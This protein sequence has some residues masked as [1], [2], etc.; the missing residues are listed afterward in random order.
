MVSKI[1][2]YFF[3]KFNY[4]DKEESLRVSVLSRISK[5]RK[6][7]LSFLYFLS[8]GSIILLVGVVYYFLISF[9]QSSGETGF[10]SYLSLIFSDFSSIGLFWKEVGVSLLASL[11]IFEISALLFSF[12]LFLV[13]VSWV[14]S[15]Y[16]P[17]LSIK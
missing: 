12:V 4:L 15:K 9:G 8:L 10:F 6:K 13:Y 1:L 11:P 17:P 2:N 14:F 5:E 3:G 7:N 16:K